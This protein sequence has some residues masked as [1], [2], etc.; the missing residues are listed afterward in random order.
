MQFVF[1]H[2][3]FN[4]FLLQHNR[5]IISDERYLWD[6]KCLQILS[7]MEKV[8]SSKKHRRTTTSLVEEEPVDPDLS[9]SVLGKS[10]RILTFIL[11]VLI[12]SGNWAWS[13][14]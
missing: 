11:L 1:E 5:Q 3:L 7:A 13:Q 9:P 2:N 14:N 10:V 12:I 8:M 4:L 6:E